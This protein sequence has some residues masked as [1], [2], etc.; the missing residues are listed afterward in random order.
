M[1]PEL[2]ATVVE[3]VCAF[4]RKT[5]RIPNALIISGDMIG[6]V[7]SGTRAA[8]TVYV[9]DLKVCISDD[10]PPGTIRVT[11]ILKRGEK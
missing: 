4:V 11:R 9:M 7:A 5:Q 1:T 10:Q 2:R 3:H 6:T 8:G